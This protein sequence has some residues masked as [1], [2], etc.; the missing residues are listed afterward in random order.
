M[1]SKRRRAKKTSDPTEEPVAD[2][3]Q[4][5][6]GGPTGKGSGDDDS[7]GDGDA[8]AKARSKSEGKSQPKRSLPAFGFAGDLLK[9]KDAGNLDAG[10]AGARNT[11]AKNS[12]ED[13]SGKDASQAEASEH[14][15]DDSVNDDSVSDDISDEATDAEDPAED[16]LDPHRIFSFADQLQSRQEQQDKD[17][18][19][20]A[21]WETWVTFSLDDET[22]ALP[23]E[24]VRQVVRVANITRVPHAPRPIRGVTNLRGRVIPVIDLRMR[25]GLQPSEIGRQSRVVAVASRGR[26]LGLL[27]DAV[28]QVVHIDLNKV[29][30]PPEDVMTIESDYILGVYHQEESLILLLDVDRA[31]VLREEAA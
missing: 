1:S 5:G 7:S 11:D 18:G 19:P 29:Q 30:P 31:L 20:E 23:V 13:P 21:K 26:L 8:K 22:F 17:K 3:V 6:E 10:G 2:E 24:P 15:A 28:H 16:D 12:R 27:V 25:V 9:K 14:T 4:G